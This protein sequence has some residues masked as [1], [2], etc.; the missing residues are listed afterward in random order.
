MDK[1]IFKFKKF[2]VDQSG[3]A[4]KI[5]TDGVLLAALAETEVHEN[6]LD[7]GTGTGVIA[8]MLAQRFPTAYIEGIEI[9]TDASITAAL[10]FKNSMFNERLLSK[11]ISIAD[12]HSPKKFDLIIS[13]PPYFVNDLKNA[14]LKKGIA[15]H[16]DEQFFNELMAKVS[17]LLTQEGSFWFI[18]PVKQAAFLIAQAQGLGLHVA[19]KIHLHSD[20]TKPAFRWIVC[21]NR[22][23]TDTEIRHFYIYEAE[24]VYTTAY[25]ELLKD[26]FLGY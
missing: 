19:K 2:T 10:N 24:K 3:C 26:F 23:N 7:V 5:N 12:Y 13:N 25:K 15:R 17:E 16:A 22:F 4:M 8:L 18:L 6:M 14:E 21:L 11:N 20:V 9:D 1:S